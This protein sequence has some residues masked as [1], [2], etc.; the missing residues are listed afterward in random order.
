[1]D[2]ATTRLMIRFLFCTSHSC[3]SLKREEVALDKLSGIEDKARPLFSSL[4]NSAY[5]QDSTGDWDTSAYS[6]KSRMSDVP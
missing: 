4:E 5:Q 2:M 3:A 1:M 6:A